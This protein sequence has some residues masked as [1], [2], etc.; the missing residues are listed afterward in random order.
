MPVLRALMGGAKIWP[1]ARALYEATEADGFGGYTT[2]WGL[3]QDESIALKEDLRLSFL[4][5][6][7]ACVPFDVQLAHDLFWDRFDSIACRR[8]ENFGSLRMPYPHMW[9]EWDPAHPSDNNIFQGMMLTEC[10]PDEHAPASGRKMAASRIQMTLFMHPVQ[11][12]DVVLFDE[13]LHDMYLDENGRYTYSAQ[14]EVPDNL[15]DRP[16]LVTTAQELM[17][18]AEFTASQAL[19]LMNCRN[20]TTE[21]AGV[22]PMRRSGRAKRTGAKPVE[23]HHIKLPGMPKLTGISRRDREAYQAAMRLHK[24]KGHYKHFGPEF[25]TGLLFGRLAGTFWW[26][27]QE[28]GDINEGVIFSDYELARGDE[29]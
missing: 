6:I 16:D 27:W 22:V 3:Y 15:A 29:S 1:L 8:E 25:G 13:I 20:V 26:G 21:K 19:H 11:H 28:R 10:E 7:T 23:Y 9:M 18:T 12:P 4:R 17:R 14:I 2:P 5:E 24:V